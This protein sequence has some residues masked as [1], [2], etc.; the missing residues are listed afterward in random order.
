MLNDNT[1]GVQSPKN[2]NPWQRWASNNRPA[3]IATAWV[4]L[5]F[6]LLALIALFTGWA[7]LPFT[8]GA[9]VLLSLV[10]GYIAGRIHR[11]TP[12]GASTPVRQGILSGVLLQATTAV[13]ILGIAILVGIGSFGALIPLMVPYFVALIPALVCSAA[14]GALGARLAGVGR[15]RKVQNDTERQT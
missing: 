8:V 14:L 4:W 13:V 5:F 3:L 2:Q 15:K 10:A 7:S 1:F 11:K 12:G 9:Q 6:F